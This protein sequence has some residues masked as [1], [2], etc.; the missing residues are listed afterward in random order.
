MTLAIIIDFYITDVKPIHL[1]FLFY[2]NSH[3][4]ITTFFLLCND[5][6]AALC[7]DNNHTSVNLAYASI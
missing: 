4:K 5:H 7:D 3:A 1:E 2:V 6:S